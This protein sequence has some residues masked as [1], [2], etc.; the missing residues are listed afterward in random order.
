[1][2]TAPALIFAAVTLSAASFSAVTLSA[3]S[4]SA[5]TLPAASASAST[6]PAAIFPATTEPAASLVAVMQ[7]ASRLPGGISPTSRPA[8]RLPFQPT[9][10]LPTWLSPGTPQTHSARKP[11]SSSNICRE[12]VAVVTLP[13][14][15]VRAT[16]PPISSA[17]SPRQEN[18]LSRYS[19]PVIFPS[20]A[21]A[22]P[23]V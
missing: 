12:R 4:L 15:S 11:P 5:V 18:R 14:T 20:M 19:S 22:S 10:R 21:S 17:G 3:A 6:A 7:P 16:R 13:E 9:V 23:R 1:M 2:S 8:S